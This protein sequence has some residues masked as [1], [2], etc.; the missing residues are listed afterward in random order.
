[1]PEWILFLPLLVLPTAALVFAL[2]VPRVGPRARV[3]LPIVMLALEIGAVLINVA[4]VQHRVALSEWSL[5]SFSLVFQID[6]PGLLL[7][8]L[9]FLMPLALWLV[10]P[11]PAPFDPLV[12]LV[13]LSAV[14]LL[15]SGN[16]ATVYFGW[17][18]L[19][20]SLFLWRLVRAVESETALRA[21]AVGQV[22]GM[23][24][25]AGAIFANAPAASQGGLLVAL[26]F[27]AR[28][29]LFPFHWVLPLRG[30]DSRDLWTAR[31]VPL[32][33]GAGLWVHW[34]LLQGSAII[35]PVGWISVLAAM[36]LLTAVIQAWHEEQPPHV[37]TQVTWH[38]VALIPLAA[39]YGGD[40]GPAY[41]LWQTLACVLA[42]GGF[43]LALRW[44]A[45]NRNHLA[46]LVC[47]GCIL[48]LAGLPLTPAFV[49]RIGVYVA[50]L[51]SGAWWFVLL[52]GLATAWVLIPLWNLGLTLA[53]PERRTATVIETAGLALFTLAYAILGLVPM[54][55]AQSLADD[56]GAAADAALSRVV[57]LQD[58]QGAGIA[59]LVVVAPV[60]LAYFW[61]NSADAIHQ[62]WAGWIGSVARAIDLGW[63]A[64]L[65]TGSGFEMSRIARNTI[66]I[67]EENPTVWLLLV[68]L[69]I[70]IFVLLPR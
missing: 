68:A 2:L 12:I 18:L 51:Q 29:G 24:V 7:M 47:I 69:W 33:A 40:G 31:G 10:A 26:A 5:A 61:R 46:R 45:E 58:L 35:F 20:T 6:G 66:S 56:F 34:G 53:S 48:L 27:W 3:W 30:S 28:L 44:R 38:A 37:V 59:F 62:Q 67:V 19:D 39:L 50:L 17:V 11:P 43:E 65:V 21:L 32:I 49:G 22:A 42:L 1:M 41:T 55:I 15:I 16:L 70:A 52:A 64:R 8:L 4:P 57:S 25:F 23:L 13:Y 60:A 63:L 54:P 9:L 14:V 36:A